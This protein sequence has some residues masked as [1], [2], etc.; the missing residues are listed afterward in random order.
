MTND[1]DQDEFYTLQIRRGRS[2]AVFAGTAV[3]ADLVPNDTSYGLEGT[4]EQ[5]TGGLG[6]IALYQMV[7]TALSCEPA[8]RAGEMTRAQQTKRALADGW[9]ACKNTAVYVVAAS[10]LISF[11]PFLALPAS[12]LAIGGGVM[13]GGKLSRAFFDA[14]TPEQQE[15]L[16][17]AAN[18]AGVR[19]FGNQQP[20]AVKVTAS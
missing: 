16:R 6:V 7:L 19:I 13:M 17:N 9:R 1:F 10:A 4:F 14:L 3:S 8:V 2:E 18:Q 12:L 15:T 11:F 20:A 5:S